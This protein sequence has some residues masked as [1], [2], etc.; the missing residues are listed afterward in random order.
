[1][2][3]VITMYDF[4]AMEL[5]VQYRSRDALVPDQFA[6]L[7]GAFV[8]GQDDR[9]AFI[10]VVD[11]ME[12]EIGFSLVHRHIHLVIDDDQVRIPQPFLLDLRLARELFTFQQLNEFAH[13]DEVYLE[14]VVDRLDS[15]FHGQKRLSDARR[16]QED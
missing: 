13:R 11:E 6:P 8:R 5:A 4:D 12:E 16:A 1:M 9:A 15:E 7:F 3:V 2:T 10:K 14:P